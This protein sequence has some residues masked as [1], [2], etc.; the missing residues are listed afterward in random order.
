M[1]VVADH[2]DGT[3]CPDTVFFQSVLPSGNR[4]M[5]VS[6]F[7]FQHLA[8]IRHL[9]QPFSGVIPESSF[10]SIKQ[11]EIVEIVQPQQ[12]VALPQVSIVPESL[13]FQQT[14]GMAGYGN[15]R[16]AIEQAEIPHGIHQYLTVRYF[17]HLG[18]FACC[19]AFLTAIMAQLSLHLRAERQQGEGN[20]R[21]RKRVQ[22]PSLPGAMPS[23][24]KRR[25][26]QEMLH[27][28]S[29]YGWG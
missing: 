10:S 8:G 3:V 2:V 21:F 27:L 20:E 14:V 4:C 19:Q 9:P 13:E 7:A 24:K 28:L 6:G 16:L 17:H 26:S 18:H 25:R 22:S 11:I 1:S 5:P 12:R 29:F 15:E 23:A